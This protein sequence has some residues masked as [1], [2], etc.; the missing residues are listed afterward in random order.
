MSV[1]WQTSKLPLLAKEASRNGAVRN[2]L[3]LSTTSTDNTTESRTC[4]TNYFL[5]RKNV[6]SDNCASSISGKRYCKVDNHASNNELIVIVVASV[7]T[8]TIISRRK[9]ERQTKLFRLQYLCSS[10]APMINEAIVQ[11]IH[12]QSLE[13]AKRFLDS[14][15]ERTLQARTGRG[16]EMGTKRKT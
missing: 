5:G 14:D 3:I 7:L 11:S 6:S 12:Y 9:K 2:K 10:T 15:I 16:S 4:S 8:P 13:A 1:T